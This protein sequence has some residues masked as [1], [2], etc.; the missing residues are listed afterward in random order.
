M[1]GIR[2]LSEQ[3]TILT[4]ERDFLT[5][6]RDTDGEPS[7]EELGEIM[8]NTGKFLIFYSSLSLLL[9]PHNPLIPSGML[10]LDPI[11]LLLIQIK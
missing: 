7:H 2:T 1:P 5:R 8:M 11:Q 4:N 10:I 9:F 3:I 6:D